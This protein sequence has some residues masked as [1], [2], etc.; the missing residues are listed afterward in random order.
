MTIVTIVHKSKNLTPSEED[1]KKFDTCAAK[2]NEFL[3]KFPKETLLD[4]LSL[5]SYCLGRNEDA[6]CRWVTNYERWGGGAIDCHANHLAVWYSEGKLK[7]DSQLSKYRKANPDKTDDEIVKERVFEPLVAFINSRGE[8]LRIKKYTS[9]GQ[10]ALLQIL[11][12]YFY[13][14]FVD[15]SKREWIE[16]ICKKFNLDSDKSIY[17]Q[18]HAVKI[19][20]DE[21]VQE[22]GNANLTPSRVRGEIEAMLN[23]KKR[24]DVKRRDEVSSNGENL[25]GGFF[26][27][28][29]APCF[30]KLS[31]DDFTEGERSIYRKNTNLIMLPNSARNEKVAESRMEQGALFDNAIRKGDLV[32]ICLGGAAQHLVRIT[33]VRERKCELVASANGTKCSG[34]QLWMPDKPSTFLRVPSNEL[35][36]FSKNLLEPCFSKSV[37]ELCKSAVIAPRYWWMNARDSEWKKSFSETLKALKVDEERHYTVFAEKEMR[38]KKEAFY[39]CREGDFIIGYS[40]TDNRVYSILCCSWAWFAYDTDELHKKDN[41]YF[42]KLVDFAVP[43]EKEQLFEDIELKKLDVWTVKGN[44]KQVSLSALT[45]SQV[46]AFMK[47]AKNLNP[48]LSLPISCADGSGLPKMEWADGIGRPRNLIRFGA[49]GTG[50]SFK[51]NDEA[52]LNRENNK[53]GHFE[54]ANDRRYERVTFYPTYSYA[55]FVGTY[56]PVMKPIIGNDGKDELDAKGNVKEDISYEFVPGPFLRMLVKALNEPEKNWCLIIEEINRANAAAVFGDVFQ[57]LDRGSDGN[58]EYAIA[59]SEDIKKHL[60]KNL[61]D[62]GKSALTELT[63]SRV[64]SNGDVNL[65]IPRNM[66]IWATMNSADQGVFPMDTAFKRRWEFEYIGVDEEADADKKKGEDARC[67]KWTI[68]GVNYKW[69]KVRR[70]INGLLSANGVNEDKLMGPYFIQ[71]ATKEET[72]ITLGAFSSKVLMYLWED[73]GRMIRR[74]LFGDK[75]G[76]YSEFVEKWKNDGINVFD[77]AAKKD[78]LKKEIKD[79]LDELI[80]P[81]SGESSKNGEPP[82]NETPDTLSPRG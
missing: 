65:K 77:A 78:Q 69:D 67:T 13:D 9:Y 75:I 40:T 29:I 80:Q 45:V 28:K 76:T 19:F 50:K 36:I 30:W 62:E 56:K 59:A 20:I 26:V 82:K 54:C 15:I 71:P 52:C 57:L 38:L 42:R 61:K 23:L 60:K 8:D 4:A 18:S 73:A 21:L 72:S 64:D 32:Y 17:A 44:A 51:L 47:L 63:G 2:R 41:F 31:I 48:D 58:S 43:V 55:Q 22:I 5:D 66:Y 10:H 16:D 33:D 11:N 68:D 35:E 46:E 81:P 39:G 7:F 53:E 74:N 49:P 25:L 3:R 14:E 12:L 70:V 24:K 37:A 6:F 1:K 34:E 27:N 79:I